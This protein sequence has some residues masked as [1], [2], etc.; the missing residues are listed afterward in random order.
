MAF[1]GWGINLRRPTRDIDFNAYINDSVE[2]VA[3]VIKEICNL[4]V[5]DGLIFDTNSFQTTT[6]MTG[7]EYEGVRIRFKTYLGRAYLWL[8]VDISF[9]N[10]ITPKEISFEYPILLERPTF[11]LWGY[12]RETAI[13]EKFQSMIFLGLFNGRLKDYYDIYLL[14]NEGAMHGSTLGKALAATFTHRNT[15]IPSNIPAALSDDFINMNRD[16]WL[17]FLRNTNYPNEDIKDL[18]GVIEF[19]RMF[20]LPPMQSAANGDD[21]DRNWTAELGWIS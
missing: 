2:A 11:E 16:E 14:A 3:S 21:F 8:Q 9:A 18:K 12:N 6:T 20:L 13:A 19:L 15:A 4:N 10:V 1:R 5:E 17:R 7:A